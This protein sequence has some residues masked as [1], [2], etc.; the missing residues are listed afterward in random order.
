MTFV[1]ENGLIFVEILQT[2]DALLMDLQTL[3]GREGLL[4]EVALWFVAAL[5]DVAVVVVLVLEGGDGLPLDPGHAV[6]ATPV[7]EQSFSS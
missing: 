2:F 1:D 7:L 4:A 6:D 5:D 3:P